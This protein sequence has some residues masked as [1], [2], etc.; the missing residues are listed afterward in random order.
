MNEVARKNVELTME[1]I[2]KRSAVLQEME[3]DGD[4]KIVGAMYD[5]SDGSVHFYE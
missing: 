5:I 2:R 4:I 1:N 3:A